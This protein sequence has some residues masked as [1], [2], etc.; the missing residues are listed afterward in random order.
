MPCQLL[1]LTSWGRFDDL[2]VSQNSIHGFLRQFGEFYFEDLRTARV[3]LG[4]RC[5]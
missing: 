4:W 2:L 3:S 5:M 1:L